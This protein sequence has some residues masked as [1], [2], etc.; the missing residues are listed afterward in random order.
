MALPPLL[1]Q[2]LPQALDADTFAIS[3]ERP[4]AAFL[5]KA[6]V[7]AQV[8][9]PSISENSVTSPATARTV[10]VVDGTA[11]M[12]AAAKALVDARFAFGGRSTYSPDVVLAHEFAMK[13]FVELVI[14]HSSKY[15]SGPTGEER[16][17]AVNPRRASSGLSF[18]D[19]AHR[20][21]SARVLVSGTGWGI[22][23]VHNRESPLLQKKVDEKV[24]VL[25]PITS[26]DDAIDFSASYVTILFTIWDCANRCIVSKH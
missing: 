7:V 4:D 9:T 10:A 13:A 15:L 1:R 25:H 11:D 18:I 19:L 24:L 8:N 17:K 21:P 20:D 12:P 3:E 22:V 26:L 14:L 6:L 2:I 23:E 16:Q 5:T